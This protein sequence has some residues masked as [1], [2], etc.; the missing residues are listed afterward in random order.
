MKTRIISAAVAFVVALIVLL[1]HKTVIFEIAIA[2]IAAGAVFELLRAAN[3]LQFKAPSLVAIGYSFLYVFVGMADNP[4]IWHY[5]LKGV[6]ALGLAL[7]F[8]K[9]HAQ[10]NFYHVAFMAACSYLVPAALAT[11]VSLNNMRFGIFL[12]VLTLCC[13]WLA[14]SG[15]YFAGTFLGKHKLCPTIS[16]KKTVEG[17]AGGAVTNG[18]LCL[19]LCLIYDK[20]IKNGAVDFNYLIVILTGVVSSVV[21]LAGDLSASLI[22]RQCGIKDYGNI[23]PGH[24]GVMDRFD[25]VIFVAPFIYF[26]VAS[27]LLF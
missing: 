9:M 8:F 21:G 16:P 5:G 25:S 15:A 24:G 27:G 12:V 22:K 19:I 6:L 18:L 26:I 20:G 10:M 7:C 3:C 17:V 4:H 14:D 23:M 2:L 13:A 11:L 1:L